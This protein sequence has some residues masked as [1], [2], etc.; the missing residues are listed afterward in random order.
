MVVADALTLINSNQIPSFDNP[1]KIEQ[2]FACF[3]QLTATET[4]ASFAVFRIEVERCNYAST[5]TAPFSRSHFFNCLSC[6]GAFGTRL[7]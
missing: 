3:R 2:S 6:A 7:K 5:V 1:K 4:I